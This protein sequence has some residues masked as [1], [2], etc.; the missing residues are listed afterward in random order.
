MTKR[1]ALPAASTVAHHLRIDAC[2]LLLRYGGHAKAADSHQASESGCF[3]RAPD[4]YINTLVK[5]IPLPSCW[6]AIIPSVLLHHSEALRVLS[7][8][9]T[10]P[11]PT[12]ITG[13]RVERLRTV[14]SEGVRHLRLEVSDGQRTL[15]VIAFRQ[16]SMAAALGVGERI[17]LATARH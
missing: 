13:L 4:C 16:G 17:D 8:W 15:P 7:R 5:L 14:G 9:A 11:E 1:A 2:R 3:Q 10:Q 6:D 12:G